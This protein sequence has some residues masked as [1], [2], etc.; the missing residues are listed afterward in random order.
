MAALVGSTYTA[1]L[2]SPRALGAILTAAIATWSVVLGGG[3]YAMWRYKQTPAARV[4]AP[5]RWPAGSA[6][7]R[8]PTRWTLLL[9]AHPEC[10]CTR[11]S[12]TELGRILSTLGDKVSPTIVVLS[13]PDEPGWRQSAIWRRATEIVPRVHPDTDGNEAIRFGAVASGYTLLYD[14]GGTLRFAGGITGARGHEGHN[15][16]EARLVALAEGRLDAL[17]ESPTF[18]CALGMNETPGDRR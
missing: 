3:T 14:P 1:S 15:V 17:Q 11:A 12:L 8:D 6:L 13:P 18:G 10:P 9:F 4:C 5:A 16:G 2:R 7:S